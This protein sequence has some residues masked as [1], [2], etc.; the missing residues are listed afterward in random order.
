L[1]VLQYLKEQGLVFNEQT[2]AS[3]AA[4]GHPHVCQ[5]LRTVEGC[6]WNAS[7][8]TA[9]ASKAESF[10]TLR[11]LHESGCPWDTEAV[12]VAAAE[13]GSTDMM[14]YV[15]QQGAR[16]TTEALL[17]KMLVK[18]CVSDKFAAAQWLRERGAQW[19]AAMTAGG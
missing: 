15:W 8:C 3:A 18:A 13:S 19:A 12:N 4:A 14:Q 16:P 11:W 5:Y 10:D 2:M 17:T 7:A 1:P 6:P 9:A